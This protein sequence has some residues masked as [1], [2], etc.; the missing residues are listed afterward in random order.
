MSDTNLPVPCDVPIALIPHPTT[1]RPRRPLLMRGF[2]CGLALALALGLTLLLT[3]RRGGGGAPMVFVGPVIVAEPSTPTPLP[4]QVGPP[5]LLP[6]QG[7]IRIVGLPPLASLSEG[8][9]IAPGSWAVPL[10]R[11]LGLVITAPSGEGIRSS[12]HIALMSPRGSVLAEAQS[13][14]VVM[15]ASRF[16]PTSTSTR[17]GIAA[18]SA[19]EC[20]EVAAGRRPHA[21]PEPARHLSEQ[22][23]RR[24]AEIL[25]QTGDKRLVEGN[26][27]AAREFYRRAA[28]MGWSPG[29]L[30]LGVTYDP[31]KSLGGRILGGAD[32][33]K[34]QCWY[35]RARELADIETGS[36]QGKN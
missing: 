34:A 35:A 21:K 3:D 22:A 2:V 7:W 18:P 4:I 15:P 33:K 23:R 6:G 26:V 27:A 10:M 19:A 25:V 5:E 20:P 30:A 9:A 16:L 12:V 31:L 11:L 28:E 32:A 17:S 29:A 36:H 8:H 1:R 24:R 13:M 14:L